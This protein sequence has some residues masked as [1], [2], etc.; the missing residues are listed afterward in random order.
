MNI[1]T[2]GHDNHLDDMFHGYDKQHL[3]GVWNTGL[4]R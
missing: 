4:H 3:R 1:V 2:S